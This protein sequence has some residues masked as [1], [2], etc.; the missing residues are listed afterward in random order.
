MIRISSSRPWAKKGAVAVVAA[1]SLIPMLGVMALA[2]DGGL[3]L[4]E[5]R[6]AQAAA[7]AAS[8]AAI[9]TYH[10]VSQAGG[11]R[12]P[13]AAA[14]AAALAYAA[15]NGYSNDGVASTVTSG[16]ASPPARYGAADLSIQVVVASHQPRLF[17]AIWG[18]G[19]VD[20]AGRSL[21]VRVTNAPPSIILLNSRDQ[22]S[23]TV[24][25]GAKVIAAGEIQV[26]SNNAKAGDINN[27]GSVK[28]PT[29]KVAGNYQLSS[30]GKIEAGTA[31]KTAS[32]PSAMVD[33][34]AS[35]AQ[36]DPTGYAT[37][38]SPSGWNATNPFPISPGLYNSG[39]TLNSGGMN[40]TMSPG[41][42]YIK[43]G[44]FTVSNGVRVTGA[45]VMIYLYNGNV[46]IQGGQGISLTAPTSGVYQNVTIF[47][48]SPLNVATGDYTPHTISIANGTSNTISGKIYAP[49]ATMTV[50]GGS[51]NTYGTQ[52]IVNKL[53]IS[54]NAVVNLPKST[55]S[56]DVVFHLAQ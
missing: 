21:S 42:Y 20:A 16:L 46:D 4:A 2:I 8:F 39:L 1:L 55:G 48:R 41:V 15:A 13:M 19:R 25:G 22:G 10:V 24:A 37:R 53:N 27:M 31:I 43:S 9:R 38:Q 14:N 49:G 34:Q 29:L 54:N 51:N 26:K 32:D 28:A 44:N 17:S 6:H 7:D 40:Y 18:Q 52:L 36:P 5:R 12:D 47:Q 56:A 30:G 33:P 3:L 50:A 23:L 11:D 45:G 35:L